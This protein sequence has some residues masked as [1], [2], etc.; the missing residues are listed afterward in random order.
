[1]SRAPGA[2]T[3]AGGLELDGPLV[4]ELFSGRAR[5]TAAFRTRGYRVL[6]V[7]VD[8]R[9]RPDIVADVCHLPLLLG[10][11]VGRPV[12]LLWCSP[13]CTEF[14][15]ANPNAPLRPSL[16]LI[17]AAL[18]AVQLLRP[19]YWVL[20][21]VRGAIPFLGIPAQKIGPWCLWGYFP[22]L[23]V[24]FPMQTHQ[25]STHRTAVARASVPSE[26]GEALYTAVER[27][28]GVQSLLDMRPFRRHRHAAA[29]RPPLSS[30]PPAADLF[31]PLAGA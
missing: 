19:R 8:R 25:K 27:S 23:R 16:E 12:E 24:T 3:A 6:T 20:E 28:R 26:L 5:A 21:N 14:S 2:V 15:D 17:F 18:S 30:R 29:Q 7:D 13:P 9:H 11:D 31:G 1:M 22:E 10:P 4:V